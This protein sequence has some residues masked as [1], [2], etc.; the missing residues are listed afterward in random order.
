MKHLN[1][2]ISISTLLGMA[3]GAYFFFEGRYALALTVERV[4]QRL[5]N[6]ILTDQEKDLRNRQWEIEDRYEKETSM[7]DIMKQEY[8]ELKEERQ[9]LLD[10][11]KNLRDKE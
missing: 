8:R 6:K 10:R 4:E 9:Q 3:F 11:I 1:T 7:P 2:I 5:E